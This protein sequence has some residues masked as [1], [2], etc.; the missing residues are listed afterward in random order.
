MFLRCEDAECILKR[1]KGRKRLIVGNHDGSWMTKV[2][3]MEYFESVY[4]MLSWK[5]QLRTYMIHGHIHN[6]NFPHPHPT[7]TESP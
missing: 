1:L 2:P 7:K 3:V 5:H 4:T 6:S